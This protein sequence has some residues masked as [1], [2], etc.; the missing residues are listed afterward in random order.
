MTKKEP[1]NNDDVCVVLIK[2]SIM[3]SACAHASDIDFAN[4]RGHDIILK[5]QPHGLKIYSL[6]LPHQENGNAIK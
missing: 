4:S 1:G 5:L 3:V 2:F 6:R